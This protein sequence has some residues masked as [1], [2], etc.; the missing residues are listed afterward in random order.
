MNTP[1]L[2][3]ARFN[4]LAVLAA[5]TL[6]S[7]GCANMVT[8][9]APEAAVASQATLAAAF[10]AATSPSPMRPFNFTR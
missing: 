3:L 9:S 4:V 8:T 6:L 7:A 5:G 1:H 10:T 2:T